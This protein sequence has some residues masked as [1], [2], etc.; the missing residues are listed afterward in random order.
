[1]KWLTAILIVTAVFFISSFFIRSEVLAYRWMTFGMAIVSLI[2]YGIVARNRKK[3]N[4]KMVG[5][6]I[7]AVVVKFMLSA[8]VIIVY[9]FIFKLKSNTEFLY[10][11]IAYIVYSV[12]TYTG[13]YFY[14]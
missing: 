11:F 4:E 10:F 6:Y 12:V 3:D 14:K 8:T 7:A 5:S 1:M 2:F 9:A 13:A